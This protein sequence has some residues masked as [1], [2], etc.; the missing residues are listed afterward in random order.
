MEA[1]A[2]EH[3]AAGQL[4]GQWMVL[5]RVAGQLRA[6]LQGMVAEHTQAAGNKVS[7]VQ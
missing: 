2:A 7:Y 6:S 5:V 3:A 4:L 1:L